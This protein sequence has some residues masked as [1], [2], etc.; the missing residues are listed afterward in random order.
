MPIDS[1]IKHLVD[2]YYSLGLPE[3]DQNTSVEKERIRMKTFF[4][5]STK[6]LAP[7]IHEVNDHF[8]DTDYGPIR[9]RSYAP[10]INKAKKPLIYLRASGFVIDNFDDSDLFC[11]K[12][13][14]HAETAV[15][16]IDYPLA[17]ENRFP[18]P[19]EASYQTLLKISSSADLFGI[20]PKGFVLIGE[21]SGACIAAGLSQMLRDRHGPSI[22]YQVLIYPI[23]EADFNTSSFKMMGEGNI[24][25]EAKVRWYLDKYFKNEEDRQK[26][27]AFPLNAK[28]FKNLPQ[29]LVITAGHDPLAD[30]GKKYADKLKSAGV[31]CEHIIYP[32]LIHG[33]LKFNGIAVAEK[34]FMDLINKIKLFLYSDS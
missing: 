16:S 17:P 33:F 21:S 13:A 27:Y 20:D 8:F 30:G 26:P 12:L 14:S 25:T 11:S 6:E 29:T 22:G 10:K 2:Y 7:N 3:F 18:I 4:Q 1:Q 19:I 34:A 9:T 15:I 31:T 24:L 5:K 28:D 32:E 23:A